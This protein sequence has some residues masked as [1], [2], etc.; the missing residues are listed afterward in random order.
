MTPLQSIRM[1]CYPLSNRDQNMKTKK[2]TH[3]AADPLI[4]AEQERQKVIQK[5]SLLKGLT[6]RSKYGN[7]AELSA[8]FKQADSFLKKAGSELKAELEKSLRFV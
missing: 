8:F 7:D 3:S 4:N 1:S 6:S 5:L 2:F